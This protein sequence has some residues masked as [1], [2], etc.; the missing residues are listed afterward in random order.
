MLAPLGAEPHRVWEDRQRIGVG[1]FDNGIE[2]AALD[3][4]VSLLLGGRGKPFLQRFQEATDR[5]LFSTERVRRWSGGSRSSTKLG[6]RHGFSL[7]KSLMPTPR[8]EQKVC[9]SF[10]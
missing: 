4:L 1:E 2:A 5:T 3:Q 8:L 9:Q 7:A 6:G 10:S